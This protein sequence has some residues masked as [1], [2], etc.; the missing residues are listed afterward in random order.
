MTTISRTRESSAQIRV[1]LVIEAG[2][3][4]PVWFEQTDKKSRDR[5]FIQQICSTWSHHQGGARIINFA[6]S[7]GANDYHLALDTTEM[8]WKFAMTKESAFPFPYLGPFDR[9]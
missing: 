4:R 5:I 1:A 6:V 7:D 3:I 9:G 2:K 8:T